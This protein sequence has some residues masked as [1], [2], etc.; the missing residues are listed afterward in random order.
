MKEDT[1]LLA[2]YPFHSRGGAGEA[3]GEVVARIEHQSHN[4][5]TVRHLLQANAKKE[6]ATKP[7]SDLEVETDEMFQNA[8]KKRRVARRSQ[9]PPRKRANKRRGR[10]RMRMIVRRSAQ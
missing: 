5:L 3:N 1:S 10:G 8:K 2:N 6:Q 7:L 4:G 9:D